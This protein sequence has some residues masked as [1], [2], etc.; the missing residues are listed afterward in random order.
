MDV[1]FPTG[2]LRIDVAG[3]MLTGARPSCQLGGQFVFDLER[4]RLRIA[5][6]DDLAQV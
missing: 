6:R 1:L 4:Y 2:L 5:G 3:T